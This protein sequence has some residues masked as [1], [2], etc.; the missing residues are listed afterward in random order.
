M[1]TLSF[2]FQKLHIEINRRQY[3]CNNVYC[4]DIRIVVVYLEMSVVSKILNSKKLALLLSNCSSIQIDFFKAFL[5]YKVRK[6]KNALVSLTP[7]LF[8]NN[9]VWLK[10]E[11]VLFVQHFCSQLVH[12]LSI[13][14]VK[15]TYS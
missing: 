1:L 8:V 9:E 3:L 7:G 10:I 15:L 14:F 2:K 11:E 5:L 12:F 6:L 13:F 4:Y